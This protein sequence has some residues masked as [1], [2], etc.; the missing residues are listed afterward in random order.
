MSKAG[1]DVAL[2]Q[3]RRE[4]VPGEVCPRACPQL[5]ERP[6]GHI[7]DLG[8]LLWAWDAFRSAAEKEF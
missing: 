2:V 4:M 7:P 6:G 1:R 3:S 5:P 8:F